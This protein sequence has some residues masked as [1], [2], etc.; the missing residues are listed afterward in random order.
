MRRQPEL[1]EIASSSRVDSS[2]VTFLE[3]RGY[4]NPGLLAASADDF[5]GVDACHW[6]PWCDGV[7]LGEESWKLK[8][9][10]RFVQK[11]ALRHLWNLRRQALE[12]K[13]PQPV[14][15]AAT[16]PSHPNEKGPDAGFEAFETPWMTQPKPKKDEAKDSTNTDFI[17]ALVEQ[18]EKVEID[19]RHRQ[20]PMRTLLGAEK[21]I[22]RV[23]TEHTKSGQYTPLH[24]HELMEARCFDSCGQ[25]NSLSPQFKA[26][27][28]QQRLTLDKDNHTL[29]LEDE[30][31]WS[32]KGILSLVDSLTAIKFC[33]VLVKLGHELDI[34]AYIQWWINLFRMKHGK[35][36]ELKVYWV[37]ASWRLALGLR[38]Q[39]D[40]RQVTLDIMEDTA[41]L[42]TALTKDAP[43][44]K[45][46][47][48]APNKTTPDRSRSSRQWTNTA[49]PYPAKWQ[50]DRRPWSQNTWQNKR[51]HGGDDNHHNKQG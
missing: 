32:P 5:A 49:S 34:E 3:K 42:Q 11:A 13:E 28:Q 27:S 43:K 33:W 51:P 48:K 21:I 17:Q 50:S 38:Q 9:N 16:E 24:L 1:A 15:P 18:Y 4:S 37:E 2:V 22:H 10:E 39:Q 47:G 30:Q 6:T 46:A 23:W 36:E 19:G 31:A 45:G 12:P 40:F 8:D 14:W 7:T 41:A 26:K 44:P 29:L 35:M 25:L 20:F